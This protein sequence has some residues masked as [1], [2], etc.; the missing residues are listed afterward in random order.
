MHSK[1]NLHPPG[2]VD[3]EE[4]R[5]WSH[6]RWND[7]LS[8]LAPSVALA[9]ERVG[10]HVACPSH[11]GKTET[12]FRVHPKWSDDG[13]MVCNTCGKFSDGF[14]VLRW[15]NGWG[16]IEAVRAIHE[17]RGGSVQRLT[18]QEIARRETEHQQKREAQRKARAAEDVRM[19]RNL[20]AVW[21]ASIA[22][23]HPDA[24]PGRLYLANRGLSLNHYP[25]ELR[26][27]PALYY[28]DDEGVNR[29]RHPTLLARL[30]TSDGDPGCLLRIYITMDGQKMPIEAPNSVKKMMESPSQSILTGGAIR[31]SPVACILGIA[32]GVETAFAAQE[33]FGINCW[34]SYSATLLESFEPPAGADKV[35]IFADKDVSGTGQKSAHILAEKLWSRGIMAG[36]RLPDEPIPDGAKGIDWLDVLTAKRAES[37]HRAA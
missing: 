15:Q 37:M 29:G 31:L 22:L 2:W 4:I 12:N 24:A 11:S 8:A 35:I 25:S 9:W 21:H 10:K 18:P 33:L 5:S 16:F 30:R 14:Q 32:E 34:S 1:S 3:P 17:Y 27:H 20:N 13:G 36:I 23:E 7:I 6:G 28:Q 26:F 19:K